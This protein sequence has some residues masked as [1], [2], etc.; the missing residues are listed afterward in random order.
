MRAS[1]QREKVPA[2]AGMTALLPDL[3]SLLFNWLKPDIVHESES[4]LL[5]EKLL[6]SP[7][8]EFRILNSNL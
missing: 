3:L 4:V 7:T 8:S 5:F 2:F 1:V 6:E